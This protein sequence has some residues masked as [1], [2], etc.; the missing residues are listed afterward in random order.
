MTYV[1][2]DTN[3]LLHYRRA[4]EID[5]LKHIGDEMV[6][7][8]LAPVVIRELDAHKFNHPSGKIRSRVKELLANLRSTFA[9]ATEVDIRRN[10]RLRLLARDPE[11]DFDKNGL[12]RDVTDDW[13]LAAMIDTRH[14]QSEGSVVLVTAD[15]GLE[16]KARAAGFS[17]FAPPDEARLAEDMDVSEKRIKQLERE[18]ATLRNRLPELR[19]SLAGDAIQTF[20]LPEGP[21]EVV[22]VDAEMALLRQQYPHLVEPAAAKTTIRSQTGAELLR[23]WAKTDPTT[24]ARPDEHRLYNRDL[25]VYY[26]EFENYLR[27]LAAYRQ[28]RQR[29]LELSIHLHNDGGAPAEDIDIHMHFPDGFELWRLDKEPPE[30]GPPEPPVKPGYIRP[31][32]DMLSR[33]TFPSPALGTVS[34][35]SNISRPEI[36][37][38]N[39]YDVSQHVRSL[40]HGYSNL[41]ETYSVVYESD[42]TIRS[43][44]I[45]YLISAANL[46]SAAKS[47]LSI[48]IQAQG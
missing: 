23:S 25:D 42:A 15:F 5:W 43:F 19:L 20:S 14:T 44:E 48:V 6:V 22:Q 13:L 40:K 31:I 28:R 32:E 24:F 46:P 33:L 35:P 29:R 27:M 4:A 21:K 45:S 7:L 26:S 41:L 18:N 39:S 17:V 30:P 47:S 12:S 1:F 36:R 37:K 16:L 8:V 2:L 10:V 11:L 34:L 9:T 3:I 38:S